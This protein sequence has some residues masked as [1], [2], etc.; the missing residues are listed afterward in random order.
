MF[1]NRTTLFFLISSTLHAVAFI[2]CNY[3]LPQ[4]FQGVNGAGPLKSGIDLLPFACGVSW[5]TVVGQYSS[6]T[7]F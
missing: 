5:S 2:P 4:L 1:K 3:L 7:F 6:P